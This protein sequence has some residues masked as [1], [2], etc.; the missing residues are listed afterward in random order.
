MMT[1]AVAARRH[2]DDFQSRLFW[3]RAASLLDPEGATIKVGYETGPKSF[4]DI[5]VEY[6]PGRA[7]QDHE[8]QAILRRHTQCKWHTTAGT[9][10]FADLAD[11]A[12]LNAQRFSLLQRALAAQQQH[13]PDGLGLRLELVTNWRIKADDPLLDLVRKESDAIDLDRLFEGKTERARMGQVR[14]HW[15]D[16]LQIDDAALSP[17]ARVL[18]IAEAPESLASLRERLDDKLAAVGMVRVPSSEAGFFYDDLTAKLLSQGHIEFDRDGFA[19]MAKQ[20]GLLD[21]AGTR[22]PIR[23]IGIRSFLHPID[24]LE[25]RCARVLNLVPSFD[26]RYIRDEK[27]W[28]AQLLPTLREFLLEEARATDAL[29]LIV[30]AHVSLAFA[31]GAVLNVKA[32]KR[33]EIEQRTAGRRFWSM[34][35]QQVDPS[36]P[37]MTFASETIDNNAGDAAVAISLTHD[38]AADARTYIK[39]H[40]PHVGRILQCRPSSGPSQSSVKC[41]AHA[42]SY[43][44][45]VV[46]LLRQVRTEGWPT[47]RL[48]VFIAAPNGFAFFL[49]QNQQALGPI[50]LYEWDFDGLRDASYRLGIQ[51]G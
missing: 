17:V 38:I 8:G 47:G 14:K 27:G 29:R 20:E 13:A 10:G 12:F 45:A 35:D 23:T 44:E 36:W 2:G 41:G 46:R 51:I 48:H 25:E 39:Q 5:F 34:D 50:A 9:F 6:D 37:T 28:Q 19:R 16:H 18:A 24:A 42:W 4:D 7:P 31:T 3:L 21:P 30:D 1:Q 43:A 49:G 40:A 32:G 26:G 33:I 15:T 22:K 11:P